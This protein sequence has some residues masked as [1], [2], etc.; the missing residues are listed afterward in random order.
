MPDF[1]L[2]QLA[3]DDLDDIADYTLTTW[4][5]RQAVGHVDGIHSICRSFAERP[6]IGRAHGRSK[7]GLRRMEY[8]KHVIFYREIEAGIRVTRILHQSMDVNRHELD[9]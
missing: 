3:E 8:G 7:R 2:S 9:V 6:G 4:G 1:L 5:E